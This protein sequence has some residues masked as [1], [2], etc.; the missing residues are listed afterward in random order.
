MHEMLS[1]ARIYRGVKL[2]HM[3]ELFSSQYHPSI[4]VLTGKLE[5]SL[6][7]VSYASV[8]EMSIPP[9]VSHRL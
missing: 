8:L 9:Q 5:T 6:N 4:V 3:F 2:S 1:V 7:W